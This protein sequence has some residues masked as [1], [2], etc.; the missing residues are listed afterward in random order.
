MFSENDPQRGPHTPLGADAL[1]LYRTLPSAQ[2]GLFL[3]LLEEHLRTTEQVWSLAREV[4]WRLRT[5]NYQAIKGLFQAL[6]QS[7]QQYVLFLQNRIKSLGGEWSQPTLPALQQTDAEQP[8]GFQACFKDIHQQAEQLGTL[9]ERTRHFMDNA[10]DAGDYATANLLSEVLYRANQLICM[11]RSEI[12]SGASGTRD[13]RQSSR[14]DTWRSN[15][16]FWAHSGT[17]AAD[18]RE[19]YRL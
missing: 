8:P 12:P 11:I 7:T 14:P 5:L 15:R 19:S 17:L 13:C 18:T 10:V 16:H 3:L 1:G 6:D 9:A 4:R 2:R